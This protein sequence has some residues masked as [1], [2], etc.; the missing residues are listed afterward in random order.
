MKISKNSKGIGWEK[1][2]DINIDG[3]NIDL[4]S[5]AKK[6]QLPTKTSQLQNDSDFATNSSVDEKI[7][8]IEPDSPS[9]RYI[10][11]R[12]YS[13]IAPENTIP[14]YVEA[15]KA[16]FWGAETDIQETS[17]GEFVLMHDTTVDRT[18]NGTGEVS[19]MTLS[20]VKELIVD[21]GNSIEMYPN[22]QVPTLKEF[23]S[24]CKEYGMTPIIEI[25]TI[26]NINGFLQTIEDLGMTKHCIVI[27]FQN[28]ILQRLRT[29]CDDIRIQTLSFVSY[30]HLEQWNFDLDIEANNDNIDDVIDKI[31]NIHRI[32][33]K[34]N[35]WTVNNSTLANTLNNEG[36]D[37]ITTDKLISQKMKIFES[38]KK[39]DVLISSMQE[40]IDML[41]ELVGA[42]TEDYGAMTEYVQRNY[43]ISIV[44]S[45]LLKAKGMKTDAVYPVI[46]TAWSDGKYYNRVAYPFLFVGE[47]QIRFSFDDA[48]YKI[49]IHTFDIDGNRLSDSGWKNDNETV[50]N[51]SDKLFCLFIARKDDAD[52]TDEYA[53]EFLSSLT[54]TVTGSI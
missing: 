23:L 35:V 29:A 40:T 46:Y 17:D 2:N 7:N 24:C 33:R 26:N 13:S 47:K 8:K 37:Y 19:S 32:G 30:E 10:A 6:S 1:E 31:K 18:T 11:H 36:V 15:G 52:F 54:I 34:I 39:H 51:I 28:N 44:G 16:G 9:V 25:K 12:G 20:Q 4:S 49:S 50:V 43:D 21:G 14:A 53:N 5:Y 45:D 38:V 22:L 42:S 27:S 48:N 41:L 3:G